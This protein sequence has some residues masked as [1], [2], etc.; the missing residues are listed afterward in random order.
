MGAD[1]G[2]D[3]ARCTKRP[4]TQRPRN[5]SGAASRSDEGKAVN[6]Y[7][8]VNWLR[9]ATRACDGE[10]EDFLADLSHLALLS[11][12]DGEPD[13]QAAIVRQAVR[14]AREYRANAARWKRRERAAICCAALVC[15]ALRD[16]GMW[17]SRPR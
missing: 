11:V 7:E 17:G 5:T 2:I 9:A 16:H 1:A 10:G 15:E 3:W 13:W 6:A 8:I 4:R 12:R 14:F